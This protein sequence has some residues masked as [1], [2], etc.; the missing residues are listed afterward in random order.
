[1]WVFGKKKYESIIDSMKPGDAL[2]AVHY[3]PLPLYR[4]TF[5][6]VNNQRR[7]K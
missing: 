2:V 7:L 4:I 5:R 6:D 3:W 1:M